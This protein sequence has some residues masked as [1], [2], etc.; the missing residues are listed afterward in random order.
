MYLVP[1]IT[2][3]SGNFRVGTFDVAKAEFTLID[4]PQ[5]MRPGRASFF[6]KILRWAN[7]NRKLSSKIRRPNSD[8]DYNANAVANSL[9]HQTAIEL[10]EEKL[11][12]PAQSPMT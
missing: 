4:S 9:R 12:L 3:V 6:F 10:T 7:G 2:F 1:A 8:V 11:A 5:K